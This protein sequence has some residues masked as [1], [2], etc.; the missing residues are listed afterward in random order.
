MARIQ[1]AVGKLNFTLTR[2]EA[3]TKIMH[4]IT[5]QN[6]YNMITWLLVNKLTRYYSIIHIYTCPSRG[7]FLTSYRAVHSSEGNAQW[8]P[9]ICS[10][11]YCVDQLMA[12]QNSLT[13]EIKYMQKNEK[14]VFRDFLREI[15]LFFII[16]ILWVKYMV[17]YP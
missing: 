7:K 6:H 5:S 8:P 4:A 9:N 12:L 17:T 1:F 3:E 16:H 2:S 11:D 15:Y 13:R 14:S 10:F